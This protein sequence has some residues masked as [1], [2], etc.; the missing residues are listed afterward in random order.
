MAIMKNK[1]ICGDCLE[2]LKT[3]PDEYM[4]TIV[5]SPPYW[6]LRDY[7]MEDQIGLE[8]TLEEYH[9]RLLEVTAECKRVLKKTG[10]MFW[11]HGDSYGGSGNASGHTEETRNCGRKTSEY[12]A[13]RGHTV[14]F[15]P[16][17]LLMQNHRLAMRMVDEQG[18]IHRN[19]LIWHKKN[20]M[21]SPVKDRFAN[22]Y[23]PVFFFSKSKKYWFDLDAIRVSSKTGNTREDIIKTKTSI[24]ATSF[25]S[26]RA[27]EIDKHGL[28][29]IRN[30]PFG[31][32]PGDVFTL[33]SQP[34]PEAHF[35]VYPEKLIEP[36]IKA[37]CPSEVCKHCGF[38]RERITENTPMKIKRS[39]WG[40]Q[41]GN[42]TAP[43]GTMISPPIRK[44][45]GWTDC[46]C[47]DKNKYEPGIVLDPFMGAGTTAVVAKKLGRNYIGIE[48]KHE[49]IEMAQ[50]RIT[51]VPSTLSRYA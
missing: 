34:F 40:E 5:T 2:V 48:L 23:E 4:D 13:T 31:K 37:G 18:W 8:P 49:Y 36:F 47:E 10:T 21:P 46:K 44:T 51:A 20:H 27:K 26:G 3:I 6:S 22:A 9:A 14:G 17:C 41:A 43:S 25:N 12:G 30:Y 7:G 19:T 39:K 50:N 33:S 16:K 29:K 35:A 24:N 15:M 28:F 45:K 38:I 32:N 1:I 11:V 42:R